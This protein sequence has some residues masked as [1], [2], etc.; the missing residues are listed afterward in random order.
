MKLPII[1][2]GLFMA[3]SAQAADVSIEIPAYD[4]GRGPEFNSSGMDDQM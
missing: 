3:A 4:S 1:A 2:V